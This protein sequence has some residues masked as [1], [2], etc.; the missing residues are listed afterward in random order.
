MKK[1]VI[2][3]LLFAVLLGPLYA[4]TLYE[5]KR[6]LNAA[7]T[8]TEQQ[9][10]QSAI[11][12]LRKSA[13]WQAPLNV[14]SK[15]ALQKFQTLCFETLDGHT[16]QAE[17]LRQLRSSIASSRNILNYT[18]EAQYRHTLHQTIEAESKRKLA[19]LTGEHDPSKSFY[20]KLRPYTPNLT[21]QV[22][23]QIC[24][25][26]WMIFVSLFI[27]RSFDKDG[28]FLKEGATKR[29]A[30]IAISFGCWLLALSYA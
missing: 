26:L 27:W 25:W 12:F 21:L 16:S 15:Q 2:I 19:A 28:N 22:I 24:F 7:E 5:A 13:A 17:C 14:F 29:I 18:S 6:L 8:S 4:R 30:A 1:T 23:A 11:S 3:A 9:D 20:K 10:Y